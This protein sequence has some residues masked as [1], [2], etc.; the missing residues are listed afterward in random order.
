MTEYFVAEDGYGD[1]AIWRREHPEDMF[2]QPLLYQYV[3]RDD[4][5]WSLIVKAVKRE[6]LHQ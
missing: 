4:V 6:A 3:V 5:L 2:P 1:L